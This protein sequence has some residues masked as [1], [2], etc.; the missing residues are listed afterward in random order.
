MTRNIRELT[1]RV[2]PG[3][4]VI[5]HDPQTAGLTRD[6]AHRLAGGGHASG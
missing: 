1:E 4:F 3:D 6:G 2:Q 5:L